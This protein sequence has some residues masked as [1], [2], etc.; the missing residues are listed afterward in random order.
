MAV[1]ITTAA[2]IIIIV[3]ATAAITIVAVVTTIAATAAITIVAVVT[4]I[5]ATAVITIAV[6]A[7]PTG[8]N[9]PIVGTSAVAAEMCH[10]VPGMPHVAP[11][12]LEATRA[13]VV[14]AAISTE[15]TV[16]VPGCVSRSCSYAPPLAFACRNGQPVSPY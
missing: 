2:A 11:V 15:A 4:I 13:P 7:A 9:A 3:V 16:K 14:V 5:A 10:V 12:L 1:A 6:V 8:P